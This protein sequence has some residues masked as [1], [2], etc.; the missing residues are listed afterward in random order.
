MAIGLTEDVLRLAFSSACTI[1]IRMSFVAGDDSLPEP[2][3]LVVRGRPRDFVEHP[4]AAVLL[5]EVSDSTLDYDRN[6]KGTRVR[7]VWHRR[8]LDHQPR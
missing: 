8:L 6:R 7:P 2:D 1:R 3:T 5:V 4:E